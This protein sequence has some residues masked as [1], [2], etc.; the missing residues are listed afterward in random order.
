[1]DVL[2]VSPL[3]Y[4]SHRTPMHSL[5]HMSEMYRT[6]VT[7]LQERLMV[8]GFEEQQRQQILG[9]WNVGGWLMWY[10]NETDLVASS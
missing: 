9:C 6:G 1:M 4:K 5:H 3:S 8:V 10:Y 2:K 7:T